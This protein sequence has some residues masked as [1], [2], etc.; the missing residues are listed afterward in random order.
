MTVYWTLP[1]PWGGVTSGGRN[2]ASGSVGGA[3]VS[4]SMD[5]RRQ[6]RIPAPESS[7]T[8]ALTIRLVLGLRSNV[9]RNEVEPGGGAS[10]WERNRMGPSATVHTSDRVVPVA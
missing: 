6:V 1:S 2:P 4:G 9:P 7:R 5:D 10:T 3:P 8:S